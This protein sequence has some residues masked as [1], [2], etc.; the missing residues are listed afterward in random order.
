V[1]CN[2]WIE[3]IQPGG[4]DFPNFI[5]TPLLIIS[6]FVSFRV[7]FI[8][9]G[10]AHDKNK[11]RHISVTTLSLAFLT[12]LLF[13]IYGYLRTESTAVIVYAW[14]T[15]VSCCTPSGNCSSFFILAGSGPGMLGLIG[16]YLYRF[17]KN[18][19]N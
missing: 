19:R 2:F 7:A 3:P 17:A 9:A 12:I 18:V 10:R 5:S 14:D 8:L 16:C 13:G 11:M 4:H 6:I 15:I 1:G